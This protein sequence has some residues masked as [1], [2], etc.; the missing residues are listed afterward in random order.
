M[1]SSNVNMICSGDTH[2]LNPSTAAPCFKCG[3]TDHWAQNCPEGRAQ[4]NLIDLEEEEP[5][6]N[7]GPLD[8]V[9]DLKACIN[10]MSAEEK[11]RLANEMGVGED[12]PMA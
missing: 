11:G 6:A 1:L 10:T 2:C 3:S 12:F 7:Y 9:G 4:S 5:D 8:S